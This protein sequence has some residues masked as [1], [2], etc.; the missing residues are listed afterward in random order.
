[1]STIVNSSSWM[2]K[3]ER[4]GFSYP[5][6]PAALIADLDL[7]LY[8]GQVVGLVGPNSCGKSTL[9]KLLA[10]VLQPTQGKLSVATPDVRISYVPQQNA[11]Y[12]MLTV[13]ENL[14]FAAVVSGL[15][16]KEARAF[17]DRMS[18]L[19]FLSEYRHRLIRQCSG[20]VQKRASIAIGLLGDPVLLL[21]D[22]PSASLDQHSKATLRD[23]LKGI[24]DK[25]VGVVFCTH[26]PS[27]LS[28]FCDR[29]IVW[30]E[31]RFVEVTEQNGK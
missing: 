13:D 10:G 30:Q 9:L 29:L 15:S 27:D 24:R 5:D 18:R 19:F 1:M 20:G 3:A 4:L 12:E 23:C 14:V 6:A 2:M 17:A 7:C 21:L 26:D 28:G 11:L 31:D 8:P 22:E 16:L 25:G